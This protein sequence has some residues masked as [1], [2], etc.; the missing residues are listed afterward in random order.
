MA[1]DKY[2]VSFVFD[3]TGAHAFAVTQASLQPT[4]RLLNQRRDR[5]LALGEGEGLGVG[6]FKVEVLEPA[7]LDRT[8]AFAAVNLLGK[9]VRDEAAGRID[10]GCGVGVNRYDPVER[11]SDPLQEISGLEPG[12]R[13]AP[14]FANG[15]FFLQ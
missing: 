15:P 13:E 14:D 5:V 4:L 6:L 12:L 10:R 11:T 8:H 7:S 9:G 3:T 1:I 2:G